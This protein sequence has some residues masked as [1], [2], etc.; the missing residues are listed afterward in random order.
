MTLKRT[1]TSAFCLVVLS[2]IISFSAKAQQFI[3][4]GD[5]V[6]VWSKPQQFTFKDRTG[7]EGT[8][9]ARVKFFKR[10]ATTC[11]IELEIKNIGKTE[12]RGIFKVTANEMGALSNVNAM[13]ANLKPNYYKSTKL[14]MRECAPKGAKSMG[15]L[16]RCKA[17]N[18]KLYFAG[19]IIK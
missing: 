5:S 1:I 2:M 19:N 7:I 15:D 14:E 18:P 8:V 17:C 6:D 12:F 13:S 9:M 3:Q 4:F 10:K 11:M 16:E